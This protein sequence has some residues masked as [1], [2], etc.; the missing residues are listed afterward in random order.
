MPLAPVGGY[1]PAYPLGS[2]KYSKYVNS[3]FGFVILG[4]IVEAVA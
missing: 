2:A 1:G 4:K 3:D